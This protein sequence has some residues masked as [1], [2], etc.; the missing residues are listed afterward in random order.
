[1]RRIVLGTLTTLAVMLSLL[2][3]PA[4]A[5]AD[6]HIT[7]ARI[8]LAAST[9]WVK[10]G[11]Q[12]TL[13]G[14][15]EGYDQTTSAWIPLP[16]KEI[17]FYVSTDASA[18]PAT[19]TDANGRYRLVTTVRETMT[20]TAHWAADSSVGYGAT[21]TEV[22]V[23]VPTR[24][25]ISFHEF[26]YS[27][28]GK[29]TVAGYFE[30]YPENISTLQLEYSPNGRDRWKLVKKFRPADNYSFRTTANWASSG[31]WRI[32]TKA[33]RDHLEGFSP[34]RKAW[35]WRTEISKISVSPG[36]VRKNRYVTVR[37]TLIR[38]FSTKRHGAYKGQKVAILFR[39]KGKKTWYLAGWAKTN[40]KGRF[41]K[42]VR[43]YGDGYFAAEFTGGSGTF[44]SGSPNIRYV[45]T[46][47][48]GLLPFTRQAGPTAP[49]W[50][51]S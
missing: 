16:G 18:R 4:H 27:P 42:K 43:A 12:V 41:S 11:G 28:Y 33:N 47:K 7:S 9:G 34:V 45:N 6:P 24:V 39:F 48:A 2:S 8:S 5:A 35:R 15:L 25:K 21:S 40:S 19:T 22:G 46:Y 1:M 26:Q 38:W 50:T 14:L 17:E 36:K 23:T 49:I 29:L 20:F 10:P 3:P 44:A 13:S 32:H 31:Y 51:V 37:G 30:A